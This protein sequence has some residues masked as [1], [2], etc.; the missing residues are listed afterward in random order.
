MSGGIARD[1]VGGL[2][3]SKSIYGDS[4]VED[5]LDGIEGDNGFDRLP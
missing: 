5:S 4:D 3:D 2:V 1:R